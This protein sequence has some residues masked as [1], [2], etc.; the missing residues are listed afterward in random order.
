MLDISLNFPGFPFQIV[1]YDKQDCIT[2]KDPCP[3]RCF[4][5]LRETKCWWCEGGGEEKVH[6][7]THATA[8]GV[9]KKCKNG[10]VKQDSG[11]SCSQE[12]LEISGVI[13]DAVPKQSGKFREM[14]NIGCH[15]SILLA[16]LTWPRQSSRAFGSHSW[17]YSGLP[18]CRPCESY[19]CLSPSTAL[20]M[21]TPRAPHFWHLFKFMGPPGR[22]EIITDSL[23]AYGLTLSMSERIWSLTPPWFSMQWITK[24]EPFIQVTLVLQVTL[25]W[26]AM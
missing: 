2:A 18:L 12:T 3:S 7:L 11:D 5:Y 23:H 1:L 24:G 14:S 15:V 16:S 26:R 25:A 21:G 4:L 8:R 19:P 10:N 20:M 17:V 13:R 22:L 6:L 9:D